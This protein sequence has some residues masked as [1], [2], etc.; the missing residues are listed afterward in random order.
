MSGGFVREQIRLSGASP[1]AANRL[2]LFAP[3]G[4]P[5]CMMSCH[6]QGAVRKRILTALGSKHNLKLARLSLFDVETG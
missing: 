6:T 1:P 5:V 3:G 2:R 4:L